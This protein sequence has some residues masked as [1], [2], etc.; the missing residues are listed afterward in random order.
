MRLQ[1]I[2]PI[3]AHPLTDD[4]SQDHE[5]D[6]N[7]DDPQLDVL[8]P[9]LTLQPCCRPLE[10]VRILVQVVCVCVCVG[11]GGGDVCT[12]ICSNFSTLNSSTCKTVHHAW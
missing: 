3:I 12:G 5:Y 4:H 10:H 6:D 1:S 11:G 8:P 9:E 7:Q 2:L